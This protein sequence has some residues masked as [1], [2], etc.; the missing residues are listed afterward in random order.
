MS[1]SESGGLAIGMSTAVVIVLWAIVTSPV[2]PVMM[3]GGAVVLA[4]VGLLGAGIFGLGCREEP[5]DDFDDDELI[6]GRVVVIDPDD[7]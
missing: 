1:R 2:G 4:C 5:I 6:E 3:F 7:L